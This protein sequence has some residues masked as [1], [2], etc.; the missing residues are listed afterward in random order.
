MSVAPSAQFSGPGH[1]YDLIVVGAGISGSEAA[2]AAARAGLDTLLV[3]TSLDTAYN[4]LGDGVIL[5]PHD[6]TLMADLHSKLADARGWVPNWE[7]HRRAK[8]TLEHQ[9]G[10]HLLQ[11]SV[12]SLMIEEGRLQGITTW[13]GVNRLA[14][15]VALCA[16]S[17]LK[18]RLTTGALTEEAGRLSEMAYDDLHDNLTALGFDMLPLRLEATGEDGSLPYTVDCCRFAPHEWNEHTFRLGRFEG[19]YAAGVCA[20]GFL[21]YEDAA[22]H[23]HDLAKA[24]LEP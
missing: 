17:F 12:S 5:S 18:A 13:E 21:S 11:S 20:A 10:I 19:L 1:T 14:P 16:G 2:L 7:F 15:R 24:L 6:S 22:L 9:P 3:T 23:G 4:L 8:Y